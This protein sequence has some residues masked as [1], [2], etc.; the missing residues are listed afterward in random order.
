MRRMLGT[1]PFIEKAHLRKACN[2][3]LMAQQFCRTRSKLIKQVCSLAGPDSED[4]KEVKRPKVAAVT[5]QEQEGEDGTPMRGAA[6]T[7]GASRLGLR[8]IIASSQT[9]PSDSEPVTKPAAP[10]EPRS[11]RAPVSDRQDREMDS[12]DPDAE[13]SIAASLLSSISLHNRPPR[14]NSTAEQSEPAH[15]LPPVPAPSPLSTSPKPCARKKNCLKEKSKPQPSPAPVASPRRCSAHGEASPT[16]TF[17]LCNPIS[18]PTRPPPTPV[19]LSSRPP[20]PTPVPAPNSRPAASIDSPTPDVHAARQ[21]Q[22]YPQ[23][24]RNLRKTRSI[25]EMQSAHTKNHGGPR[26]AR[27]KYRRSKK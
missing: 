7:K 2:M 17:Q 25:Q 24:A 10:A 5:C 12:A 20:L 8:R 18:P 4:C 6:A 9:E 1:C 14:E 21:H 11:E 13:N 26:E 15:A 19:A 27:E 22:P 16:P 23:A 3:R